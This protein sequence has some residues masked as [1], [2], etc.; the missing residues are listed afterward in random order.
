MRMAHCDFVV[1]YDPDKD[2][3]Y[4]ITKRILYTL[5]IK[6]IKN[7]KPVICFIG[8]DSGEGKSRST[9]RLQQILAESQGYDIRP[10]FDAMNVYTPL[11]YP[12]KIEK[13]LFDKE[14]KKANMITMHEAREVVAAKQWHSFLTQSVADINTMSRAIKRLIVF[15]VSQFI[16][17]I[18][19]DVRYTLNYYCIVRRPLGRKPRL[20]ISVM[21]KDDR[22]L[23]KPKLKKRKVAGYLVY[24]DGTYRRYVPQY[25]ELSNPDKDLIERFDKSDYEAKSGIIR[26]KIDKL[27]EEMRLDAD[28]S[29]AKLDAM[30]NFYVEQPQQLSLLGRRYR[31]KWKLTPKARELHS[32]NDYEARKFE[33]KLGVAIKKKGLIVEVASEV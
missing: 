23:E 29:N 10:Y 14:Y 18:T 30:V 22:D 24:P 12:D 7:K 4:D 26:G 5:F 3:D 31:G 33:E 17:D 8:G 16:R 21:W 32:L 20:Y 6:R 11:Q 1:K 28:D 19:N 13:L 15:I 9:I 25:L 27:M 2:T